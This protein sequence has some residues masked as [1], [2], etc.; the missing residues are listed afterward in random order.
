MRFIR[1]TVIVLAA[2]ALV[3]CS[4]DPN[5]AKKRYMERGQMFYNKGK[6]KEARILFLDARKKDLLYGPAYY[7]LGLVSAKMGNLTDAVGFFRRAIELLPA[8][9]PDHWDAAVKLS[10]IYVVVAKDQKSYMDEVLNYAGLML[11]RDP[12]SFDGHRLEGDVNFVRAIEAFKTA[13]QDDGTAL[14]DASIAEYRKADSLKP[15]QVGVLMQL[16]RAVSAKAQYPEAEQLYRRVMVLDKTYQYAYTELYRL[17]LVYQ[18]KIADGEQVLKLAIANNPKQYSYLTSLALHYALQRRR[19][20][21]VGVLQQIKAHAKE[22]EGAYWTVGD[23]YL[24]IGDMDSAM[25][26]YRDGMAKDPSHKTTY[27]KR[28]IEIY[29]RLGK[30]DDAREVASQILKS[31]PN[32]ADARSLLASLKLETNDQHEI[33]AALGEL[34]AVVAH[35]P[36]NPVAQYNLG[37]AHYKIGEVEQARQAFEKAIQLRPDYVLAR[38]AL[39]ELQVQRAEYDA[40]LTTAQDILKF[41]RNNINAKL[42]ES[43]ALMGQK[44][45]A[46]SRVLLDQMAKTNPSSPDVY[47]QVGVMNLAQNKYK[48]AED[49]FQRSYQLDPSR[50]RGLLGMVETDMAQNRGDQALQMLRSELDKSPNRGDLRMA[51]ANTAALMGKYDLAVE[52]YEKLL[53]SLDKNSAGRGD[54]YLRMG[55]VDRRK[56]DLNSAIVNLQKAREFQPENKI[57][58]ETLGLV[59]DQAGRWTEAKQVYEAVLRLDSNDPVVLNNLAFLM[60]E[61]NGDLDDAL[62]KAQRAKQ[63]MP[64]MTEI[65]DTLGWIFLKKN[66]SDSALDTFRELVSKAPNQST[67]RYHLG[68]A[69]AQKG[70]KIKAIQELQEALK[71]NPSKNERDQIQQLLSKLGA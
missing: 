71:Y 28:I 51:L 12:N 4:R 21:M 65:S 46:E 68:M 48:D 9:D 27:E 10:D 30:R 18:G 35:A 66:L 34:Q 45:F 11:K 14:L 44:K 61:H 63:L 20:D 55:E 69:L 57:A 39:A 56:G 22:F 33:K 29:M 58:L 13:R 40:A 6:Y 5:V 31:D 26:E 15:N 67:Y 2:L 70:D 23:F 41:D 8:T 25:R 32:D 17:L 38:L 3:S 52:E 1:V 60:A 54:V 47:F 64:E 53:N 62:G 43:A 36:D 19:D 49:A 59:L 7:H 24:R 42:T 50:S 37:R 16:A